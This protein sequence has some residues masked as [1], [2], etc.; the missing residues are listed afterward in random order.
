MLL[1]LQVILLQFSLTLSPR[2]NQFHVMGFMSLMSVSELKV[3][4]EESMLR[5]RAFAMDLDDLHLLLKAF[6]RRGHGV[7]HSTTRAV[8]HCRRY[9]L[10]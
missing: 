1:D 7:G 5:E 6:N 4:K 8:G 3:L 9:S 10:R 2:L